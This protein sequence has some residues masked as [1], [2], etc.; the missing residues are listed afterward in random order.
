MRG[1]NCARVVVTLLILVLIPGSAWAIK[2]KTLST[3]AEFDGTEVFV[4]GVGKPIRSYTLQKMEVDTKEDG[5]EAKP[6]MTSV[7]LE[8]DP[9][10]GDR[11]VQ[12]TVIISATDETR[13]AVDKAAWKDRRAADLAD[14]TVLVFED[15]STLKP[16][17]GVGILVDE[18]EWDPSNL[19]K[20]KKGLII[21]DSRAIWEIGKELDPYLGRQTLFF[22][23]FED[24]WETEKPKVMRIG[25]AELE[26]QVKSWSKK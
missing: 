10:L 24:R 25:D 19:K 5:S 16:V 14:K 23:V 9:E 6:R 17:F 3:V 4:N 2:A 8:P 26:L 15:G 13:A 7:T 21:I 12:F 11:F 20:N 18:I 1:L 22:E